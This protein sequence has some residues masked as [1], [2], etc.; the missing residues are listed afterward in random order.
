MYIGIYLFI[1]LAV[2]I[3]VTLLLG[4]YMAKVFDNQPTWLTPMMGPIERL[5]LGLA[6][7]KNTAS[8]HWT[9]YILDFV[10]FNLICGIITFLILCFQNVLPMN[11]LKLAGMEPWQAFNTICSFVT[12]TNWQSYSGEVSLSNLS[13]M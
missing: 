5:F 4:R 6:G 8:Q 10:L 12:N 11:P 3:I 2:S 7:I 9:K 13:Q 1:F